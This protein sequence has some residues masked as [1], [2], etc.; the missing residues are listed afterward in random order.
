[1][2]GY[3]NK[4]DVVNYKKKIRNLL[5]ITP[6][7]VALTVPLTKVFLDNVV[8]S[9]ATQ[10]ALQ[11]CPDYVQKQKEIYAEKSTRTWS[12]ITNPDVYHLPND[13]KEGVFKKIFEEFPPYQIRTISKR[14]DVLTALDLSNIAIKEGIKMGLFDLKAVCRHKSEATYDFLNSFSKII[15]REDLSDC[16]RIVIDRPDNEYLPW[17][18]SSNNGHAW[19]QYRFSPNDNKWFNYESQVNISNYNVR[20]DNLVD[21]AVKRDDG[22]INRDVDLATKPGTYEFEVIN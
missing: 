19:L 8:S 16:V 18:E 3:V 11:F 10:F 9:V 15:G 21:R 17:N 12:N 7:A 5:L 20:Q 13:L 22:L 4:R 6:V 1:M 14:I 2:S